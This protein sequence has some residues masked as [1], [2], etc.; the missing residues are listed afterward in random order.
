MP[1]M[2]PGVLSGAAMAVLATGHCVASPTGT[3]QPPWRTS[4]LPVE[5]AAPSG[6]EQVIPLLE[7][8]LEEL[9]ARLE[10]PRRSAAPWPLP[11]PSGAMVRRFTCTSSGPV[12]EDVL[13][14]SGSCVLIAPEPSRH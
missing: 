1:R 13:A 2:V 7:A 3:R 6:M 8:E 11:E 12:A 4:P 9:N 14:V 10:G 5:P